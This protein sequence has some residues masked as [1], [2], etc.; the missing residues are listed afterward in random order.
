MPRVPVVPAKE[1]GWLTRLLYW[2]TS[3]RYGA[4][5]EPAAVAAN[6]TGV[7]LAW[8]VIETAFEKAM[9]TLPPSLRDLVVYRT[10]AEVGCSWCV[11]FGT[12]LQKVAGMD[13]DRLRDV[14][15]YR[16][17]DRFTGLEKKALAYADAMTAQPPTVTDGQVAELDRELGHKGLVELSFAI[18]VENMRARCYNALGITNQGF[19]SGEA[20]AIP[21]PVSPTAEQSAG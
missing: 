10:A 11:D 3:R 17:S 4:V 19:T 2:V 9:K 7:L 18:A 14:P 12:M 20:C 21:M 15:N 13:I 6:H 16:T 1:A 5:P 8:G